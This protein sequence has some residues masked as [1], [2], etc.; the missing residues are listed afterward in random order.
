ML[1]LKK[2][3]NYFIFYSDY[4]GSFINDSEKKN[5]SNNFLNYNMNNPV[6]LHEVKLLKNKQVFS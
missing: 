1:K 6:S 2:F 3:Y 5:K 4:Y